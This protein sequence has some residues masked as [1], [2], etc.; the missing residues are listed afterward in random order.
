MGN[1]YEA[2]N[3]KLNSFYH[4]EFSSTSII[5]PLT[6][7]FANRFCVDHLGR[8]GDIGRGILQ[9]V[10]KDALSEI[11]L[12]LLKEQPHRFNFTAPS[13]RMITRLLAS[14]VLTNQAKPNR[15]SSKVFALFISKKGFSTMDIIFSF[16]SILQTLF[17]C[18]ISRLKLFVRQK[19]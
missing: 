6:L 13:S 3:V 18:Q 14:L 11:Q 5:N 9:I 16:F 19:S 8:F 4:T 10:S 1:D 12:R 17:F 7:E 2:I 15:H